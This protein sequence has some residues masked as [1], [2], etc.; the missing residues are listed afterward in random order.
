M[1]DRDVVAHVSA[2]TGLSPGVAARVVDDVVAFYA[3]PTDSFV[4]RRH[5]FHKAHGLK[6]PD[7]F[8]L[9]GTELSGRVV[10][11]PRLTERQL[12]RIIYG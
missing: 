3:E 8:R 2:S 12:R 4:R 1:A 7:I 6:N 9:I 5:A 11:A 10:S